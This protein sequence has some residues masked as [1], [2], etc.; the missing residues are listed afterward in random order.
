ARAYWQSHTLGDIAQREITGVVWEA[1]ILLRMLGP[2]PLDDS[3]VLFGLPLAA[4]ALIAI[5]ARPRPEHLLLAI[6]TGLFMGVFAWYVPIAAG[7]RFLLPLL[8]PVLLCASEGFV[9]L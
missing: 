2:Y 3:R 4:C 8:A 7:E 6:W 1:F 9:R 5:A